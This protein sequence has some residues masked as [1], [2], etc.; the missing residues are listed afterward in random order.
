MGKA[1]NA[2]MPVDTMDIVGQ[3]ADV[4]ELSIYMIAKTSA[5]PAGMVVLGFNELSQPEAEGIVRVFA[6]IGGKLTNPA[7]PEAYT[8]LPHTVQGVAR[9]I[10]DNEQ[11]MAF[12]L[13]DM[14]RL[15]ELRHVSEAKQLNGANETVMDIKFR[16]PDGANPHALLAEAQQFLA[17]QRMQ[18]AGLQ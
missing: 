17:L 14:S 13:D 2:H 9:I 7:M 12:Q 16:A 1:A 10:N 4:G 8:Y 5:V 6:A 15:A 11:V 3:L 18:K